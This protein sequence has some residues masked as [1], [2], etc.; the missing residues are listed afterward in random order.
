ML[1][2]GMILGCGDSDGG[3][4]MPDDPV[5]KPEKITVYDFSGEEKI[6]DSSED[7]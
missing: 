5:P 2:I 1:P 6:M 7:Q 3:V 4:I